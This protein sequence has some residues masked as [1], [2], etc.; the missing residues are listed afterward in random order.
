MNVVE[1]FCRTGGFSRGAHAAGFEVAA[2]YDIDPILTSSY[3]INFPR[4]TLHHRDVTTPFEQRVNHLGGEQANVLQYVDA[5]IF[6]NTGISGRYRD[7]LTGCNTLFYS[8]TDGNNQTDLSPS[9]HAVN[10]MVRRMLDPAR[11]QAATGSALLVGQDVK[12]Y[13]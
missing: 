4:T 3:P 9:S 6:D 7:F 1:L 2:A 5:L 10:A 12:V 13:L 11:T 8:N